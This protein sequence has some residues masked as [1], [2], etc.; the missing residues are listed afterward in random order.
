MSDIFGQYYA[1][2]TV[3]G[4]KNAIITHI[5][6]LFVSSRSTIIYDDNSMNNFWVESSMSDM[7]MGGPGQTSSFVLP[8]LEPTQSRSESYNEEED[9]DEEDEEP[10]IQQ[11]KSTRVPIL[12]GCGTCGHKEVRKIRK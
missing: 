5:E 8:P 11:Q 10:I 7:L 3:I 6:K 1:A 4:M 2:I 9:E 12:K